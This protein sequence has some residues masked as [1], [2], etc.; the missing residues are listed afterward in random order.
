MVGSLAQDRDQRD[1]EVFGGLVEGRI[2]FDGIGRVFNWRGRSADTGDVL[3][4][5]LSQSRRR[6][7][8]ALPGLGF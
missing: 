7:D 4:D 5:D 1:Q 8:A 3:A 6:W 2:V